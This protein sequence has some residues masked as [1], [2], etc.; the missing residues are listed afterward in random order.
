LYNFKNLFMKHNFDLS[1]LNFFA[2]FASFVFSYITIKFFLQF[3]KKFSL[4]PFVI[5]RVILGILILTYVH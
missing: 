1:L 2:V 5:Y 3:L 4:L